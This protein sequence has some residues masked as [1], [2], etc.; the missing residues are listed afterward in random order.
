MQISIGGSEVVPRDW[1]SFLNHR[2]D[3]TPYYPQVDVRSNGGERAVARLS[4]GYQVQLKQL[5]AVFQSRDRDSNAHARKKE[6]QEYSVRQSASNPRPTRA[7]LE[8]IG[9][10]PH[11]AGHLLLSSWPPDHTLAGES[12]EEPK[13]LADDGHAHSSL[14]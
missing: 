12:E 11:V 10:S 13:L 5:V 1:T 6:L 2:K 8:L 14:W 4:L 9:G 3:A 7:R